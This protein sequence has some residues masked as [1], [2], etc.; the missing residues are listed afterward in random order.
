MGTKTTTAKIAAIGFSLAIAATM[1]ACSSD[2][3]STAAPA[4]S[5][6]ASAMSAS[7][8]GSTADP[9]AGLVGTGC[10]AYAEA[11]PTG[12]GSLTQ[13]ATEKLAVAVSNNPELT[14][15]AAAVSGGLNPE[16]NLVDTLN[17]GEF[18]V[19]APVDAAFAKVD[20][21]TIDALKTDAPALTSLLTY[22]V[23][24]GQAAP[25]KVTGE[26]TTV[27]GATL[28]VTGSGDDLKVNGA[29]VI[30]G[31]IVTENATVYL[32][33]DVLMPPADDK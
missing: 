15:L 3:D 13:M 22:H 4:T 32:I 8:G 7:A 24:S 33:D 18:T 28:K 26:H 14:T 31:G 29:G 17:D 12:P 19:F 16:V 30:C 11:V 6:S 9:A 23:V 10:A 20:P 27:E 21:A 25:D 5:M 1:S 2:D